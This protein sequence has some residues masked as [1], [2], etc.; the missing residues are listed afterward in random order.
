MNKFAESIHR[1]SSHP[2]IMV[3]ISVMALQDIRAIPLSVQSCMR[4]LHLTGQVMISL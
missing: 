4:D 3:G 1:L 2:F